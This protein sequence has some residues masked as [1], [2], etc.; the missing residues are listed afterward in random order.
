MKIKLHKDTIDLLKE[1]ISVSE[2]FG[3]ELKPNYQGLSDRLLRFVKILET[4]LTREF[5]D[6]VF[7]LYSNKL[8][9]ELSEENWDKFDCGDHFRFK[10]NSVEGR[11]YNLVIKFSRKHQI[12]TVLYQQ[13]LFL[14]V[15]YEKS[16]LYK[17]SVFEKIAIH[18][19]VQSLQ[20]LQY[21][22]LNGCPV[23]IINEK[24]KF[25]TLVNNINR[26]ERQIKKM[27]S[28]TDWPDSSNKAKPEFTRDLKWFL[29]F[30]KEG[31]GEYY[32]TVQELNNL[33]EK[34]LGSIKIAIRNIAKAIGK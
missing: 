19:Y 11:V 30:I 18:L 32:R 34:G 28:E 2:N 13:S 21:S 10:D 5:I 1:Y 23:I 4:P 7:N 9:E 8:G 31:Q 24:I 3:S 17:K 26:D 6:D 12:A 25:S 29:Q 14:Y 16:D 27:L 22:M 15:M 33:D 20:P